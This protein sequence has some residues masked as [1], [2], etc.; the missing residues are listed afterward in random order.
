MDD[1]RNFFGVQDVHISVGDVIIHSKTDLQSFLGTCGF[2][3]KFIPNYANKAEPLR[4][5]TRKEQKSSWQVKAFKALKEAL[6]AHLPWLVVCN[7]TSCERNILNIHIY[8]HI[9]TYTYIHIYIYI[10]RNI[11]LRDF[12]TILNFVI[13]F[14][15]KVHRLSSAVYRL[16]FTVFVF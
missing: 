11:H 4:K 2:V 16:P 12:V 15:L 10:Y 9:Y 13:M 6:L 1:G 14:R 3:S 7:G 5:L 8:I